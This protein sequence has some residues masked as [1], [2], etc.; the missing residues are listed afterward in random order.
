MTSSLPNGRRAPAIVLA[1]AFVSMAGCGSGESAGDNATAAP[2]AAATETASAPSG[3]GVCALLTMAEAK[4]AYSDVTAATQEESLAKHGIHA[5]DWGAGPGGRTFQ[6]RVSN[7][8]VDD[9]LGLFEEGVMDPFKKT[10][11]TREAFAGGGQILIA[12]QAET[13]DV[14]Q[15]V[16]VAA[17]Q[18]G[19]NTIVAVTSRVD[20]DR[21]SLKQ[22]LTTLATAAASRAS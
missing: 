2:G 13:P 7:S 1:A 11:L 8:S 6:V 4:A 20:G 9:E 19:A 17:I 10:K 5:C 16:A 12:R 14:V 22:R 3:K 18:K 21:E 15:D